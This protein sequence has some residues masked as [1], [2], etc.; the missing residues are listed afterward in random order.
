MNNEQLTVGAD[1]IR[2]PI[3]HRT[4]S[5]FV[6]RPALDLVG[7]GVHDAPFQRAAPQGDFLALCAHSVDKRQ[8]L[9]VLLR[10]T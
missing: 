10:L 3:Y 8:P 5:L 7:G 2:P 4:L 9:Q 6:G 1:I